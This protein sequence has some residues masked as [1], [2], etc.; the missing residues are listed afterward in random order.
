MLVLGGVF[1]VLAISSYLYA[2][3]LYAT[4]AQNIEADYTAALTTCDAGESASISDCA[5][6]ATQ[7]YEVQHKV[8]ESQLRTFVL[9]LPL[10]GVTLATIFGYSGLI[11]W[12]I[13]LPASR[14]PFI[15]VSAMGILLQTI[16]LVVIIIHRFLDMT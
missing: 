8:F 13:Q 9:N 11:M 2:E 1:F 15:A 7:D 10:A 14:R 6:R 16:L 12:G 5:A 3:Y 4:T